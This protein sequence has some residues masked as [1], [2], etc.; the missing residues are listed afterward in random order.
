MIRLRDK[1]TGNDLG[2]ISE[3]QFRFLVDQ[4]EEEHD[5]DRDY[6]IQREVID[7]L[8]QNGGGAELIGL[9]RSAVGDREG[10]EVAWSSE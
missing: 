3:E 10:V 8:E 5:E 6:Y 9:L 1:D 4:L 7:T 2:T